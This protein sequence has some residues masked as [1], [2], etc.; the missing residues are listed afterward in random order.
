MILR[1]HL[2]AATRASSPS[3]GY[4]TCQPIETQ[5]QTNWT[6]FASLLDNYVRLRGTCAINSESKMVFLHV[7]AKIY[8]ETYFS[9]MQQSSSYVLH[10]TESNR[11]INQHILP[12]TNIP[13]LFSC[14]WCSPYTCYPIAIYCGPGALG[15]IVAVQQQAKQ[16]IFYWAVRAEQYKQSVDP[17]DVDLPVGYHSREKLGTSPLSGANHRKHSVVPLDG[18]RKL[19]FEH[20][21]EKNTWLINL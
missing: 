15:P 9:I 20:S 8:V 13:V 1:K 12:I 10:P 6:S 3:L 11:H 4:L 16:P 19:L 18:P 7:S 2:I 5:Y 21:T 17:T 14:Q